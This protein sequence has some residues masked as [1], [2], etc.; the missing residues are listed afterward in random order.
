MTRKNTKLII[1]LGFE[2]SLIVQNTNTNAENY[3]IDFSNVLYPKQ[4]DLLKHGELDELL[5]EDDFWWCGDDIFENLKTLIL[6]KLTKDKKT[7][8]LVVA[9]MGQK[10]AG[11]VN[12]FIRYAEGKKVTLILNKNQIEESLYNHFCRL[13][14]VVDA[15]N[16]AE[17]KEKVYDENYSIKPNTSILEMEAHLNMSFMKCI[18]EAVKRC[19]KGIKNLTKDEKTKIIEN[20]HFEAERIIS[21]A[22]K[23]ASEILSEHELLKAVQKE[24]EKIKELVVA[25]C[26]EIKRKT[27]EEC[28]SIKEKALGD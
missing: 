19:T 15:F 3:C 24:A 16:T 9:K 11:F 28:E 8:I 17:Y 2:S 27:L 5:R 12:A 6:K 26:A 1:G 14:N 21:N 10:E 23:T 20:A 13:C 7:I 18:E 25:E 22:R 4:G